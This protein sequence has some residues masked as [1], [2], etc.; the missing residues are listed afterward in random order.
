MLMS[1]YT[2]CAAVAAILIVLLDHYLRTRILRQGLFWVFLGVMFCFKLMVN[3]YLTWRPIVLYGD[4]HYL[5]V[6]LLTIPVEDFVFG[7]SLIS[8]SIISWEFFLSKRR[9]IRP[10]QEARGRS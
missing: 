9:D 4:E 10:S 1:E 3:G 7:F 6:R 2:I 5:G 8:A